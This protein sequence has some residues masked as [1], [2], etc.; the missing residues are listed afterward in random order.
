MYFTV[1]TRTKA[2]Y[3]GVD[4]ELPFE[5]WDKDDVL[6]ADLKA[7]D[8]HFAT[9]DYS[10]SPPLLFIGAFV[11]FDELGLS[12]LKTAERPSPARPPDSIAATAARRSSCARSR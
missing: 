9:L 5:Y 10:E 1:T 4:G 3:R 7:T 2:R 11:E 12:N 6:F 8:G